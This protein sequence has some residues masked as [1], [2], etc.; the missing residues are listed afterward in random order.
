MNQFLEKRAG[1]SLLL[2]TIIVTTYFH[3]WR[4][5][6]FPA[7]VSG[8]EA[9]NGLEVLLL[10]AEPELI[11]FAPSNAGREALFHY[12]LMLP[13]TMFGPTVFA[14]RLIPALAGILIVPLSYR[15]L[16]ALLPAS[17]QRKWIALLAAIFIGTSLWQLQLSRLGLRGILL[18]PCMLGAYYFFWEGYR[19]QAY[20][21][22]GLSGLCL[23]LATHTYTASR[24]LPLAFVL[25]AIG[26]TIF[27]YKQTSGRLR[28]IWL[29]LFIT[30]LVSLVVFAPLGWYFL[31]HP[32]AF[33][34][35]SDQVS[36][37]AIY[38]QFHAH[39][40]ESFFQFLVKSWADHGRW[41]VEI[42]TPWVQHEEL[43]PVLR[44]LP[45]FFWLGL[46]R[47]IVLT[48]R[49][50]GYAFLLVSFFLGILPLLIGLPTTM[51][52]IL[53][54][55]ATYAILA[56]GLY[57]PF[58][59]LLNKAQN[60]RLPLNMALAMSV[61]AISLISTQSL[62]YFQHWVG[63]PPLPTVFDRAFS[64]SA[65]R[66]KRLVIEERQSVLVP[67]A[68]H[69][70][71]PAK[72]L[73]QENFPTAQPVE[74]QARLVPTEII[75]IFWPVEWAVW[76]DNQP[77]SF[78]LLSPGLAGQTGY[79][80]TIGQWEQTSIVEFENLLQQRLS[81]NEVEVINDD[82]GR[83]IGYIFQASRNQILASLRATPQH[84]S[85]LDFGGEIT[86][87]GYD[88]WFLSE[89]DLDIGLFWQA[90][91]NLLEDH[92][93]FLQLVDRYGQ[94]RG[95][96]LDSFESETA[97]WIP[98]QLM[99]DH[100]LIH[101]PQ[102]LQLGLYTLK[103]GLI[104]ANYKGETLS[105]AGEWLPVST[106]TGKRLSEP[107]VPL[108]LVQVGELPDFERQL[109]INFGDALSL[110]GYRLDQGVA[111]DEF[112]ISLRWQALQPIAKDYTFTIQLFDQDQNL[113]AQVDKPPFGG[114]YP[115]TAWP[116]QEPIFDTYDL[117]LP[118]G[119]ADSVYQ[120][121]VGVY[122]FETLE[123][124]SVSQADRR[125]VDNN[126]VVLYEISLNSAAGTTSR[127]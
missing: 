105:I 126:L 107:T 96:T 76:F 26:I 9:K 74:D 50:A 90:K 46:L 102:K 98:G 20:R 57:F 70:F 114:A 40:G 37:G 110:T 106:L 3:L 24:S 13:L 117:Q 113:I 83:P 78:V 30:G 72:F 93:L 47:L 38:Q 92:H 61:L 29:G 109:R 64:L 54:L 59:Y 44:W 23:G 77:P 91:H 53:G 66:V 104:K 33:L 116:I 115:T 112:Q 36:L 62:F 7:G 6:D 101:L 119:I 89:H 31:N 11:V 99:I 58:E 82:T 2:V 21:W 120:L 56:M 103:I 124:L 45:L 15:W 22:F 86:L 19:H 49:H 95:E 63:A 17:R 81:A 8:D 65:N 1:Y 42:S 16:S 73:L 4:L 12:L 5:S 75:S 87:S 60:L 97:A 34:F 111:P 10:R 67:Q 14:L 127:E 39:T 71:P 48:P 68:V 55:P 100:H 43:P 51:R 123:R 35:R 88:A 41:F 85:S 80:E 79:I 108:G 84:P 52:V 125:I 28:V 121:A 25:L 94:V 118:E 18:I 122:D 69:S 32:G 27:Y